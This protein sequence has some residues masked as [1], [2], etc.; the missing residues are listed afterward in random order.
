MA[1]QWEADLKRWPVAIIALHGP[2]DGT[3]PSYESFV[4]A[5]EACLARRARHGVVLDLTGAAPDARRR[6]AIIDWGKQHLAHM[7]RFNVGVAI[8]ASS[9]PVRGIITAARWV[10]DP[11]FPFSVFATRAEATTWVEDRLRAERLP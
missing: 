7:T 4:A 1:R 6:K 9:A 10:V 3:Q 5:C 11:P 2:D 8:V